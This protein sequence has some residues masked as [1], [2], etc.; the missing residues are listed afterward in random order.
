[1]SVIFILGIMISAAF[2]VSSYYSVKKHQKH[3]YV[4]FRF[5]QI[6]RDLMEEL[7]GRFDT[8]TPCEYEAAEFLLSALNGIIRHYHNH[9]ITMFN[10]RKMR[11]IVESDL[12]CHQK[13]REDVKQQLS[14]VPSDTKISVLYNDFFRAA[15]V[16]F[17]SYTPFIRCEIILRL[18]WAEGA[19]QIAQI[20][21]E[22][23][24]LDEKFA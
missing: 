12:Q 5:C 15:T 8:L 23:E 14:R 10:L 21:H 19:K 11:R 22:R 1:M 4:L 9:K 16:A 20:R 3:D 13:V 7:R 17:L 18:L 6:R 2:A 24:K